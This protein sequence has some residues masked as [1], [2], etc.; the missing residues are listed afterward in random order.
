MSGKYRRPAS[1]L[2][3]RIENRTGKVVRVISVDSVTSILAPGAQTTYLSP[4]DEL[5]LR[6]EFKDARVVDTLTGPCRHKT[7]TLV[8]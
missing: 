8:D 3:L 6:A 7:W 2:G 1:P 5:P 4:C